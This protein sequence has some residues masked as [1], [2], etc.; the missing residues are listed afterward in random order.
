MVVTVSPATRRK[1]KR[2]NPSMSAIF[3]L[4]SLR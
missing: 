4:P 3:M 1:M 2:S